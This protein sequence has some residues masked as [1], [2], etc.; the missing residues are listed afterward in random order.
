MIVE[1]IVNL[2]PPEK[3]ATLCSFLV[4]L[5]RTTIILDTTLEC[6]LELERRVGMQLEQATLDDLL[7][8][9]FSNTG[10]H[11]L[12]DVDIVHRIIENYLQQEEKEDHE[13][14]VIISS[15]SSRT[16][17]IAKVWVLQL[18][19]A[20]DSDESRSSSDLS[21]PL[22]L[23]GDVHN[24][25]S[26]SSRLWFPL[27]LG[28]MLFTGC[29]N[30]VR[31]IWWQGRRRR[32]SS[33]STTTAANC[34]FYQSCQACGYVS[35]R[36][37]AGRQSQA[38]QVPRTCGA[39]AG[40]RKDCW[41]WIVQSY[42]YLPQG[43]QLLLSSACLPA[44]LP[45]WCIWSPPTT[46][47]FFKSFSIK[48]E[49]VWSRSSSLL[50]F[51]T[52]SSWCLLNSNWSSPFFVSA[53]AHPV[54]TEAERKKLC[55]LMDCQKLSQEAC[56]HAAQNERLPIHVVVQI[57][58]FEQLRLRSAFKAATA[59]PGA[60]AAATFQDFQTGGS[61]SMM[62]SDLD[63]HH[64]H[65]H[66]H[67][68][69]TR[70][71]AAVQCQNF[72]SS[73]RIPHFGALSGATAP[74]AKDNYASVRRENQELKLEI[75]RMRMRITDLE[76]DHVYMKQDMEKGNRNKFL[77]SV[78]RRFSK[79][80]PFVNRGG[81]DPRSSMMSIHNATT[82]LQTPEMRRDAAAAAAAD[83]RRRRHSIS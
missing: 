1:T 78:S 54:L 44:C 71:A 11:T 49:F 72:H 40:L 76:K 3:N 9:S 7:I 14:Q 38:F 37:C 30:H 48:I 31:V 33:G 57:L 77:S 52:V 27:D 56:T 73:Q 28:A 59:G 69:A 12:F 80:N 68:S 21:S 5:L 25:V 10:D 4:G 60:A 70:S 53:Q 67:R 47:V 39:V 58:Y 16:L 79:L 46:Y 61:L 45:A 64:Q 74:G 29:P 34:K 19:D 43:R 26:S 32:G 22:I 6:R 51:C 82:G 62:S 13:L 8:P 55:K 2:L 63:N 83:L 24:I 17:Q 18:L 66:H 20:H 81:R 23:S 41:R 42:W 36:D 50:Q 35:C 75:A 15:W 65:H